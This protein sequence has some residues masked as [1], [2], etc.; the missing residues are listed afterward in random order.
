MC[1]RGG[2]FSQKR[3]IFRIES[4]EKYENDFE[5]KSSENLKNRAISRFSA[6]YMYCVFVNVRHNLQKNEKNSCNYRQSGVLSRYENDLVI[7]NRSKKRAK[8]DVCKTSE[9]RSNEKI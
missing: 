8:F 9:W 4:Y 6:N 1:I 5:N 3:V 2:K 7:L